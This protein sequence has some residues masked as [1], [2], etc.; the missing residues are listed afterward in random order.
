VSSHGDTGTPPA[1]AWPGASVHADLRPDTA[2]AAVSLLFGS[3]YGIMYHNCEGILLS[4]IEGESGS[5]P[6]V[7]SL[8][9]AVAALACPAAF[10]DAWAQASSDC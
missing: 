9:G 7:R 3:E 2:N 5:A 1:V 6:Y 8:L 10:A 4:A